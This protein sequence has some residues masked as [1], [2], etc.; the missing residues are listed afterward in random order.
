MSGHLDAE[1]QEAR[2]EALFPASRGPRRCILRSPSQSPEARARGGGPDHE[3]TP[4]RLD[5][6]PQ[7]RRT[8]A[9]RVFQQ[10]KVEIP[11]PVS[12]PACSFYCG[13][14]GVA[15]PQRDH[16]AAGLRLLL[17]RGDPGGGARLRLRA[18]LPHHRRHPAHDP[19]RPR[20][21][22]R[23]LRP[24]RPRRR[25]QVGRDAVR[26]ARRRPPQLEEL[27]PAVDALPGGGRH[28]VQGGRRPAQ[29]GVPLQPRHHPRGAAA[30]RPSS[31]AAAATAS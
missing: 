25:A 9:A 18:G 16:A 20:G 15:R 7:L 4:A 10:E 6:L 29:A 21:V 14:H 26:G 27:R 5:P 31:T 12:S 17:P 28:L 22:P 8:A 30:A 11:S 3:E 1:V 13:R 2:R 19:Q 24:P 23:L